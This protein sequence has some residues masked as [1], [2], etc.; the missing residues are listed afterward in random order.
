MAIKKIV[1][2][3]GKLLNLDIIFGN[4]SNNTVESQLSELTWMKPA[5]DMQIL[6]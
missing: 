5:S 4:L 6:R 1:P 3:L 2:G